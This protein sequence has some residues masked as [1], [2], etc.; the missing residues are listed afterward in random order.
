L[1][2]QF[3]DQFMEDPATFAASAV[4]A[5]WNFSTGVNGQVVVFDGR[6]HGGKLLAHRNSR[7]LGH[8]FGLQW[9]RTEYIQAGQ[10]YVITAASL[11]ERIK[12]ARSKKAQVDLLAEYSPILS[13]TKRSGKEPGNAWAAALQFKLYNPHTITL[14]AANTPSATLADAVFGQDE[15]AYG[16]RW[17]YRF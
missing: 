12:L 4:Y 1:K 13:E 3:L 14:S 16:F 17:S 5:R 7:R 10:S 9:V 6:V 2:Y 11:G 15:I 8:Y